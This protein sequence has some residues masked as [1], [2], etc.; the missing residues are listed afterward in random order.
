[1]SSGDAVLAEISA[2]LG[3]REVPIVFASLADQPDVLRDLWDRLRTTLLRGK[4]PRAAKEL[5]LV[6]IAQD[7]S[8]AYCEAA[9]IIALERL[10]LQCE[11]L[12]E[13]QALGGQT[14]LPPVVNAVLRTAVRW[15]RSS[16]SPQTDA[17]LAAAGLSADEILEV[18]RVADL[19]RIL[20]RH[21]AALE[22]PPL[23]P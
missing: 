3:F 12:S 19:A 2:E 1:M 13:L 18:S 14:P 20:M 8:N 23:Q 7:Q 5:A 4:L 6:L 22:P 10:G 15:A 9:H 17:Q 11:M 16:A 21:T